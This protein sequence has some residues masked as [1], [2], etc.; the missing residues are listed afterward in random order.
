MLRAKRAARA[1]LRP[2]GIGSDMGGFPMSD[3]WAFNQSKPPGK[4]IQKHCYI[5]G[6][7]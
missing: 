1:I 5:Y 3:I 4:F 6:A 7:L 2:A